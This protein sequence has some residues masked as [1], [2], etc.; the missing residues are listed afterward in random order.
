PRIS[1]LAV[2]RFSIS[3]RMEIANTAQTKAAFHHGSTVPY[4]IGVRTITAMRAPNTTLFSKVD[5]NFSRKDAKEAAKVYLA[6]SAVIAIGAV[7]TGSSCCTKIRAAAS[8]N[9]RRNR[10]A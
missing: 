5:K 2:L 1:V 3:A 4:G 8:V 7:A 10:S 6:F 9:S